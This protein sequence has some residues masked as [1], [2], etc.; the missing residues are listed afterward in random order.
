[1]AAAQS[2]QDARKL[3]S[4]LTWQTDPAGPVKPCEA[5]GTKLVNS[6]QKGVESREKAMLMRAHQ[7]QTLGDACR[8]EGLDPT[9]KYRQPISM[10]HEVGWRARIPTGA[11]QR[12]G[13]EMF[14]VAEH[15]KKQFC[16]KL[17]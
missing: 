13:L 10:A 11:H 7:F 16:K 17:G 5:K 4:T 3:M 9:D 8:T 1:M 2:E 6:P 14:G 15:A 12:P